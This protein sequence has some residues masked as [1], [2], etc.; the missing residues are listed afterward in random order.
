MILL[1]QMVRSVNPVEEKG[2]KRN[3][4]TNKQA[5]EID[6]QETAKEK[7]VR[8]YCLLGQVLRIVSEGKEKKVF[9][10]FHVSIQKFES[11]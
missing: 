10:F 4:D 8:E 3:K 6:S 11:L 2:T 9:R 7:K 1:N 5:E